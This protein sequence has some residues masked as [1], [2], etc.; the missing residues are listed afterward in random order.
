MKRKFNPINAAINGPNKNC[1][2]KNQPLRKKATAVI[3][4]IQPSIKK[5]IKL[6]SPP[7]SNFKVISSF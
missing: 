7:F 5:E 2:C 4:T 1:S 6:P 3:V